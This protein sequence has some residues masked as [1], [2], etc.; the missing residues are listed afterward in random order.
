MEHLDRVDREA[1]ALKINLNRP[2]EQGAARTLEQFA[3][4]HSAV[5]P[6]CGGIPAVPP[7]TFPAQ[8]FGLRLGARA[9][10]EEKW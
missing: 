2:G 9:R 8:V 4:P 5:C 7:L 1:R 10:L 6:R 3:T